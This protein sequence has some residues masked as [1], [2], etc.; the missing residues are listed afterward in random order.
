MKKATYTTFSSYELWD[1]IGVWG[2]PKDEYEVDNSTPLFYDLK[3]AD[4]ATEKEILNFLV[5][6]G[7]LLTSDRRRVRIDDSTY[8]DRMEIYEVKGKYPI[9]CLIKNHD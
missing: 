4:D 2:N 7:F 3:I 9:G 1:Y 8:V 5:S 6:I